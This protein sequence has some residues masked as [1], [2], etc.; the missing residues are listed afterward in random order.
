MNKLIYNEL[1]YQVLEL[2]QVPASGV[3]LS[4]FHKKKKEFRYPCIQDIPD[5]YSGLVKA[6]FYEVGG[7]E[8]APPG[9]AR[10]IIR[11]AF[12]QVTPEEVTLMGYADNCREDVSL[13]EC[14]CNTP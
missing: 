3:S 12:F 9:K 7:V 11:V 4:F 10:W 8:I 6:T 14:C 2:K 13:E 1:V 5:N